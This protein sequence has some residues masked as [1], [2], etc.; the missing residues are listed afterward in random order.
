MYPDLN[1][2]EPSHDEP[3]SGSIE[4]GF[5]APS[6]SADDVKR[7]LLESNIDSIRALKGFIAEYDR[8]KEERDQL[9]RQ[10]VD[11]LGE[12]EMLRNQVQHLEIQRDQFSNTLLTLTSQ[13][14]TVVR[15]AQRFIDT[16]ISDG[17]RWFAVFRNGKEDRLKADFKLMAN[18]PATPPD[19]SSI[20]LAP[21]PADF[22]MKVLATW[23]DPSSM[24]KAPDL[25]EPGRLAP[26]ASKAE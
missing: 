1:K 26:P 14:G 18:A 13:M 21:D 12:V 15:K 11:S 20:P 8:M 3:P 19:P 6:D 10:M 9:K 5:A 4:I 16:H 17:N 25:A 24:R 23:A 2:I 22:M 7:R